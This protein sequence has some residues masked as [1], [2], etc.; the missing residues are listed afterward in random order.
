MNLPKP[1]LSH[2]QMS[3][4]L[5]SPEQYKQ[6]YFEGHRFEPT[7]YM[8]HGQTIAKLIEQNHE[9]VRFV[10]RLQY[11]EHEIRTVIAGV[12]TLSYLDSFE[13]HPR[14][15]FLEYK[16]SKNEW[17][18]EMVDASSQLLFYA[19]AI[20]AAYGSLPSAAHL[21][22]LHT[23][24]VTAVPDSRGV[25]WEEVG[26]GVIELTGDAQFFPR[27]IVADEV[28]AFEEEIVRVAFEISE[29]WKLYKQN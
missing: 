1:Y 2:T 19:A 12:P 22:W 14:F 21:V 27:V 15:S 11:P 3:L 17:S 26:D 20:R 29:A 8:R 6:Q 5:K 25:V 24:L 4:W 9:S 28:D 13:N 18:Q 23:R 10:P 7:P 16:C